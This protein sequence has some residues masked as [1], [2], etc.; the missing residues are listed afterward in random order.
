MLF[1]NHSIDR[2][3]SSRVRFGFV[4]REGKTCRSFLARL[5]TLACAMLLTLALAP[6]ASR[7]ADS[8]EDERGNETKF[9][10]DN[11]DQDEWSGVTVYTEPY[12]G[13]GNISHLHMKDGNGEAYST[14][15]AN[16]DEN[17]Y[18]SNIYVEETHKTDS[19]FYWYS[20]YITD[21]TQFNYRLPR[22]N[23]YN[24][25]AE[26][27]VRFDRKS[28]GI[29]TAVAVSGQ[30]TTSGDVKFT[31][32]STQYVTATLTATPAKGYVFDYWTD[33][34]GNTYTANPLTVKHNKEGSSGHTYTAYFKPKDEAYGVW[35]TAEKAGGRVVG[36]A[37]GTTEYQGTE[38]QASLQAFPT[39]EWY[40]FSHWSINRGGKLETYSEN[41][42]IV[43]VTQ[44]HDVYTAFFTEREYA[45]GVHT[46][47]KSID[48]VVVGV[49]SGDKLY[50]PNGGEYD[51]TTIQAVPVSNEYIF[52]YWQDDSGKTY[53]ANPMT[54]PVRF[55][56]DIFTAYFKKL[57]QN[58]PAQITATPN[59][60]AAPQQFTDYPRTTETP[61]YRVTQETLGERVDLIMD[62]VHSHYK[63]ASSTVDDSAVTDRLRDKLSSKDT[64]K[65][66]ESIGTL[67]DGILVTSNGE[68]LF[69]MSLNAADYDALAAEAVQSTFGARYGYEIL[70]AV[71]VTPP[72]G[73]TD[74]TRTLVWKDTGAQYGKRYLILMLPQQGKTVTISPTCDKAGALTFTANTI[75]QARLVLLSATVKK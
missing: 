61:D 19:S 26:I 69:V 6:R 36:T 58:S 22:W 25:S 8:N 52:D 47:A 53:T 60:E 66:R 67:R 62:E 12:Q 70:S 13:R 50:H 48:N 15:I 39:D 24:N 21:V 65:P 2:T 57:P 51:S 11:V 20:Y 72:S 37:I 23:G 75:A 38:A 68:Q 63:G 33:D 59:P 43:P 71:S 44:S 35:V 10:P 34:S 29:K 42:L 5:M 3:Q 41:P 7:A 46:R 74:G 49:T 28:S 73:F 56:C 55:Y 16:P 40:V 31:S 64:A 27:S 1:F 54:V 4:F 14:I 32:T 17:W 45:H 18:V 30:G 9:A